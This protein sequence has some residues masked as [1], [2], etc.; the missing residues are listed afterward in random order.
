M[1]LFQRKTK[2]SITVENLFY[3]KRKFRSINMAP[4]MR[5]PNV[6]RI[7]NTVTVSEQFPC[8]E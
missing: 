8:R 2:L 1:T 7:K 6:Y 3:L 5:L 4:M